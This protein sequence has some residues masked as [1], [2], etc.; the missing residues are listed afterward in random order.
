MLTAAEN[1]QIRGIMEYRNFGRSGLKVS[2][3]GIGAMHFGVRTE[4]QE[5]ARIIDTALDAGINY[6]DTANVYGKGLCEEIIGRALKANGRRERTVLAT[7][8]HAQ[9][10]AEDVNSR[11]TTRNHIIQMCEGS[12]RRLQT[13][14]V[15]LYQMHWMVDFDSSMEEAFSTLNDLVRQG[16][17][18]YIG[19][20]K[21]TPALIVEAVALCRQNG[22]EA[23]SSEH[24]PYN[25]TDR[26]IENDLIWTCQRHGLALL[27]W[28]PIGQGVLSGRLSKG[29]VFPEDSNYKGYEDDIRCPAPALEAADALKPLAAEKGV[30]LAEFSLAWVLSQPGITCAIAGMRTVAHVTSSLKALEVEFTQEDYDRIDA[31][32]PPGTW[33][34]DYWPSLVDRRMREAA[35]IR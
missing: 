32:V 9:W 1:T 15:D 35:G 8:F 5:S 26:S 19:T 23:P 4:E 2:A 29:E 7:K 33:V 12:L 30:S 14:Y 27:P 25:L 24:P 21:W 6:I 28:A 11:G 18:R 31:I 20:S 16:K 34:A 22:W 13:D 17:V 10:D 3:I